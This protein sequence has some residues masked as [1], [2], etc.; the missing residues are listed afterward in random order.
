MLL[1]HISHRHPR[2]SPGPLDHSNLRILIVG[3]SDPG[4]RKSYT[5]ELRKIPR[6]QVAEIGCGQ[7]T[8]VLAPNAETQ[9]PIPPENLA[10]EEPRRPHLVLLNVQS[11]YKPWIARLREAGV[12]AP[13]VA[14][15]SDP[16][17][18]FTEEMPAAGI[19]YPVAESFVLSNAD[20]VLRETAKQAISVVRRLRVFTWLGGDKAEFARLCKLYRENLPDDPDTILR[21]MAIRCSREELY[22]FKED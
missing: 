19:E 3:L 20:D 22:S 18:Q 21:L 7:R 4:L 2:I 17:G 11:E 9:L 14:I 15:Y 8:K 10:F 1:G 5:E 13:I 12:D 6:V 16:S